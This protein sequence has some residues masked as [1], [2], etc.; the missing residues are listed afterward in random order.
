MERSDERKVNEL[1]IINSLASP[2]PTLETY[3]YEMPGDNQVPIDAIELFDVQA[4]PIP[5]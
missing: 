1:W 5:S 3:K 2:R 4:K